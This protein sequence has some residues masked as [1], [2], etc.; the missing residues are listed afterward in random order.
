[1]KYLNVAF[2]SFAKFAVIGSNN[3]LLPF[4]TKP[5]WNAIMAYF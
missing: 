3:D 2:I 4:G 1:M 5:L